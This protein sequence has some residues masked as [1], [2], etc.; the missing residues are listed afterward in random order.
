MEFL[1][2]SHS[3]NILKGV[4]KELKVKGNSGKGPGHRVVERFP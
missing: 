2:V 1:G 3:E 4:A